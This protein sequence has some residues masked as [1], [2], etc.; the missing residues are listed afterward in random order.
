MK[1]AR[2]DTDRQGGFT[3][4]EMMISLSVLIPILMIIGATSSTASRTIET[5][6]RAAD[7]S[8]AC[9]RMSQRLAKLVRPAS[10]R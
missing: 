5:N 9:R 6:S 3:I 8:T 7:V 4:I 2:H 10:T 1:R